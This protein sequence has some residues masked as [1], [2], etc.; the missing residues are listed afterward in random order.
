[1]LYGIFSHFKYHFFFDCPLNHIML[2]WV[3]GGEG[4]GGG[5]VLGLITYG[6]N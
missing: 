1:M 6:I 3:L 5:G 4:L 2:S